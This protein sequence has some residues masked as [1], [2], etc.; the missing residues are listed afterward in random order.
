MIE[1]LQSLGSPFAMIKYYDINASIIKALCTLGLVHSYESCQENSKEHMI[2]TIC[3]AGV[4]RK[5][6]EQLS[7]PIQHEIDFFS[8]CERYDPTK[9]IPNIYML[10]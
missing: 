7:H 8:I 2:Q 6:A 10:S 5:R 1:K 4:D 9:T 3:N